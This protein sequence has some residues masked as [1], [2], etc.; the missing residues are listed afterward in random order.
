MHATKQPSYPKGDYRAGIGLC[1]DRAAEYFL[2][3][4]CCVCCLPV[5][6]L[7]G[8][9]RLIGQTFGLCLRVAGDFAPA[10]LD[11][12]PNVAGGAFYAVIIHGG[13]SI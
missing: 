13:C 9:S 12:S 4:S 8:S 10:L 1:F 6:V 7:S 2:E 11:L 3:P 5:K